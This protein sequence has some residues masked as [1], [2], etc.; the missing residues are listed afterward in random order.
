MLI[1]AVNTAYNQTDGPTHQNRLGVMVSR[2]RKK[3]K[4]AGEPSAT[5]DSQ[6]GLYVCGSVV[7]HSGGNHHI[8]S[9]YKLLVR[10]GA[11]YGWY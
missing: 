8:V 11:K 1:E 4:D 3:F 10:H 5:L 9:V 2:M 6:L 7:R